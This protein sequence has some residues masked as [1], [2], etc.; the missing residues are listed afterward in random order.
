MK[1]VNCCPRLLADGIFEPK[2]QSP[3]GRVGCGREKIL[4]E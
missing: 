1:K 3:K 2:A 4:V